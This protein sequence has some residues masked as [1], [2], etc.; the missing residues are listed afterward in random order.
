MISFFVPGLP[1][2]QPRHRVAKIGGFA[3]AYIPD[4][5]PVHSW[6]ALVRLVARDCGKIDGPVALR[7]TF[8]FPR[9]KGMIWKKR[10]MPRAWCAKKPDCDNLVKSLQDSLSEI[11]FGDDASVVEVTIRKY[12]G[13]ADERTGVHVEI[14]QAALAQG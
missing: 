6:K 2:A 8:V 4:D 10:P 3:R 14:E 5:H 7:A 11:T 12:I 9:P 13:A 1:I